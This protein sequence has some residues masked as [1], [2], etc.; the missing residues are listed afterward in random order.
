M[1]GEVSRGAARL[2]R[3]YALYVKLYTAAKHVLLM[4]LSIFYAF[5]ST[6]RAIRRAARFK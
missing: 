4:D 6:R 3:P 5:M 2:D 1:N